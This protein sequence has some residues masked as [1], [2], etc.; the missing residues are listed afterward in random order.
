M[1]FYS[2]VVRRDY[3]FAPNPFS[4]YCTLA[5]CKPKIRGPACVGDWIIGTGSTTYNLQNCIIFMMK[6][7]EILTF[8][9]Y[10]ND[11]RFETKKANMGGSLKKMYGDN[12]YHHVGDDWMQ[13]DSH[14]SY[15]GGGIN[16]NNLNKDTSTDAVLI[17]EEF[18]YFGRSAVP[19]PDSY[20]DHL[21][22]KGPSHR[23]P[24]LLWGNRL[25]EYISS[26][27]SIGHHDDP[28]L[29]ATF[30]RYNGVS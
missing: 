21:I 20:V 4:G 12:I 27:Y 26:Q 23:C 28:L 14:H 22:K 30:D 18:Y 24:E 11:A 5:T 10:W 8:D 29:F 25:L 17:S 6:V 15:E 1:R 13:E 16:Y 2:Y 19:I 9:E 7:K 3:G